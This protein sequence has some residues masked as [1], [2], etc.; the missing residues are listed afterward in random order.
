MNGSDANRIAARNHLHPG[1]TAAEFVDIGGQHFVS[2]VGHDLVDVG[3]VV[4]HIEDQFF[5][6]HDMAGE[7]ERRAVDEVW[8]FAGDF[9][10]QR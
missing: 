9:A 10:E 1:K 5:E 3:R 8:F 7:R 6:R 2:E 4:L